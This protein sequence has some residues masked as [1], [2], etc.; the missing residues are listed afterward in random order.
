MKTKTNRYAQRFGATSVEFAFV[1]PIILLFFVGLTSMTQGFLLRDT[2][3]HAAYEGA[4]A[5]TLLTA[6]VETAETA[7]VDFLDS[8]KIR[9]GQVEVQPATLGAATE[10]VTV[11]VSIPYGENAWI[12]GGFMSRDWVAS[13]SVTLN[14]FHRED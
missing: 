2:A 11:V 7:V 8:M 12:G 1:F 4:R 5:A 13:G 6:D 14:R 9:G 10:Q 3:Q